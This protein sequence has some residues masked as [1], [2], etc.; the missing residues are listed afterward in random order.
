[1][2]PAERQRNVR[3]RCFD[4]VMTSTTYPSSVGNVVDE[5]LTVLFGELSE[6]AGQRNAIDG[7][8]V[9]IAAEIER[10][11]LWGATGARSVAALVAWKTGSSSANAHTITAVANRVGG[12]SPLC[13][14]LARGPVVAGSGRR[15]RRAGSRRF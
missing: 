13:C 4:G 11:E 7:R 3:P 15:H 6:L 8:I 14:G 1:M 12:V 2:T 5:R 9:E 10:D